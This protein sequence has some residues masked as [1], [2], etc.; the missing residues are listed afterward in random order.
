VPTLDAADAAWDSGEDVAAFRSRLSTWL[1]EHA[2]RRGAPG[3]FSAS[4]LFSA[5]ALDEFFE[6]ERE[7]FDQAIAW[8]RQ[9]NAG[10]WAGLSWPVEVG[11]QGLPVWTE[12]VFAEEQGRFGVST[13]VLSVGIQM[14]SSAL[15][16][17]GTSAQQ[18]R[19]LPRVL[20]ADEVWCQ[21]FSEPDAGSDLASLSSRAIETPDGWE[22]TG[23]K[24]WTSGAGVCDLG[25]MLARS[26]PGSV[27]RAGLSCFIVP[28]DDDTVE[29]RPLRE[30][31]GAYHFNEV[32]ISGLRVGPDALLGTPG[33]GW[34]VARAVLS[35][36]RSS[37]GGGTSARSV[38]ELI[39]TLK[40]RCGPT[41][42]SDPVVRQLVVEAYIRESIL[43]LFVNRLQSGDAGPAASSISK[44][45]YS[46]H[47]RLTS[48]VAM[49]LVGLAAVAGSEDW[50]EAWEDRF[51]FSPG[52]RIGGGTDEI[53][54]NIIAEQ[55]LGLP[56]EL[57]VPEVAR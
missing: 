34:A 31:S 1:E 12:E 7:A 45:L 21:L 49:E 41:R 19:Y 29:V 28:M 3:D 23:Q 56:R 42:A 47:A 48:S 55:G 17:F 16:Q 22:I 5:K 40:E 43:D 30:M 14:V 46:E 38:N 50:T 8:Q 6:R 9:L 15:R 25:L 13:K 53:Q 18:V 10:G 32:F 54:R 39:A 51:L 27:G 44:L 35:S 52:L 20:A 11:G 33:Q 36:E 4:H 57:R 37:I 26:E 24:V 2:V